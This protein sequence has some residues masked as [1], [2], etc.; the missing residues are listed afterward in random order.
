MYLDTHGGCHVLLK[1]F[2][3]RLRRWRVDHLGNKI[4]GRLCG[5]IECGRF[6]RCRRRWHRHGCRRRHLFFGDSCR[7]NCR[8][9]CCSFRSQLDGRWQTRDGSRFADDTGRFRLFAVI[10][11]PAIEPAISQVIFTASAVQIVHPI[12]IYKMNR[13]DCL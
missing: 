10:D 7:R 8:R 12:G 9:C 3:H 4:F 1:Y 13:V 2:R 11:P 6:F 5:W